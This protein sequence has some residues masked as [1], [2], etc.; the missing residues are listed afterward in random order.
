MQEWF[1]LT[2]RPILPHAKKKSIL[3]L[4][5]SSKFARIIMANYMKT[6]Y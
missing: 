1:I 3:P 2:Y 6:K 4:V 5:F